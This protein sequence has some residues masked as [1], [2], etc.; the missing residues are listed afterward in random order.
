MRILDNLEE[1][2]E[3]CWDKIKLRAPSWIGK[4]KEFKIFSVSDL[5]KN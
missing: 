5:Y 3:E 4:H 1:P 2:R